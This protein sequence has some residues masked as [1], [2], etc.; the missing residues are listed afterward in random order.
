MFETIRQSKIVIIFLL[1]LLVIAFVFVGVSGYSSFNDKSPTVAELDGAVITQ[2][3][4]GDLGMDRGG[5]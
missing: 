3:Q 4:W 2:A 1:G 5:C